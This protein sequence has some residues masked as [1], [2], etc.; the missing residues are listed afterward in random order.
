M[1]ANRIR[2]AIVDDEPPA[3]ALL[4]ML[5]A[6]QADVEIVGESTNG[7]EAVSMLRREEPDLLF[8]DVQMP[9]GSA[10]D[11]LQS[12]N[13]ERLP[14]TIFVTAHDSYAVKAFEVCAIDYLLKPFDRERFDRALD[15]ARQTLATGRQ[16][17]IRKA[18]LDLLRER[19]RPA[20][21]QRISVADGDRIHFLALEEILWIEAQG[22]YVQLHTSKGAHLLRET[23]TS[24]E[25]RLDPDRFLRIHRSTIVNADHI[26][27]LQRWFRGEYKV[28]LNNGTELKLSQ[29]YREGLDKLLGRV[30][31]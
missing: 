29:N 6:A 28:I 1:P 17:E 23:M 12:L 26:Q 8:L 19:E 4:R 20:R 15:R 13:P 2:A 27:E 7:I 31:G 11:V 21:K 30:N 25:R 5:L 22:N 9:G 16:R 18:I 10:F 24:V 14:A 3:R